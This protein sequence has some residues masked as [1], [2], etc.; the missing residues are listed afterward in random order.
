MDIGGILYEID[1]IEKEL[2][3]LRKTS[4]ELSKRRKTLSEKAIE[5]LKESDSRVYIYNGKQYSVSEKIKT[6]RKNKKVIR[7]NL[8]ELFQEEGITGI[9]AEEMY[10]KV[11]ETIKGDSKT[12]VSLVAKK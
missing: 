9:D 6:L 4:S 11:F 10:K 12:T 1:E 3:R 8:I 2:A 7:K 5:L